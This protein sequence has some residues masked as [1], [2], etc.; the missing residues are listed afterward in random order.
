MARNGRSTAVGVEKDENLCVFG[1]LVSP[2][3]LLLKFGLKVFALIFGGLFVSG[4]FASFE[5]RHSK[6]VTSRLIL[7]A[8]GAAIRARLVVLVS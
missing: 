5:T 7:I 3:H 2:T 6:E 4:L 8:R 1:F